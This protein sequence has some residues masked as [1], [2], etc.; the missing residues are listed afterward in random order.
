MYICQVSVTAEHSVYFVLL[1]FM[2][3]TEGKN[4]IFFLRGVLAIQ[5]SQDFVNCGLK[6]G[7]LL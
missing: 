2:V 1:I 5:L 7:K 3:L 6:E 4:C